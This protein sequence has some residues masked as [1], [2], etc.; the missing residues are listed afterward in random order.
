MQACASRDRLQHRT[1][2]IDILFPLKRRAEFVSDFIFVAEHVRNPLSDGELASS[3]GTD[4][5]SV[6]HFDFEKSMVHLLQ[7]FFSV[8]RL[9]RLWWNIHVQL[10]GS[11]VQDRPVHLMDD[12]LDKVC[13]EIDLRL[14]DLFRLSPVTTI[15]R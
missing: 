7:R 1:K 15:T 11:L 10:S 5:F 4:Q 9:R 8:R 2:T 3:L 12:S 14:T 6:D 13:V